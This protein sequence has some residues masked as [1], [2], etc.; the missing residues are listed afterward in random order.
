[1]TPEEFCDSISPVDWKEYIASKRLQSPND[2]IEY[3][4]MKR[5]KEYLRAGKS[6]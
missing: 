5:Y 3:M 4:V 2:T 1:M 6:A